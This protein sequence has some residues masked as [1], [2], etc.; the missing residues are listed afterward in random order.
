[1]GGCSLIAAPPRKQRHTARRVWQRLVAEHGAVL[2]ESTVTRYVASRRVK[3]GLDTVEVSVPRRTEPSPD[4]AA[5]P[6]RG[7]DHQRQAGRRR[8]LRARVRRGPGRGTP[9]P[10]D[11]VIWFW[12]LLSVALVI[13]TAVAIGQRQKPAKHDDPNTDDDWMNAI[14]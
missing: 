8:L 5:R 10:G 1:M 14:R 2:S 9:L 12:I 13:I 6:P 7:R 3:L 4:R 11:G